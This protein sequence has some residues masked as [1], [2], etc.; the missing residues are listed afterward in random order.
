VED[1]PHHLN[2]ALFPLVATPDLPDYTR[3]MVS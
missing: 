1:K 2:K 3:S